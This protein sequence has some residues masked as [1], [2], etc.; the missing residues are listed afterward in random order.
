MSGRS[1]RA[2]EEG[3]GAELKDMRDTT[4]QIE[5]LRHLARRLARSGDLEG[6]AARF[7]EAERIAEEA[8]ETVQARLLQAERELLGGRLQEALG[9]AELA[10]EVD[11]ECERAQDL[12]AE[13]LRRIRDEAP[14]Q[15]GLELHLC[16]RVGTYR[17]YARKLARSTDTVIELG[18]AEGHTTVHL[19]RRVARVIAV[20]KTTQSLERGR[21][22]CADFDNI[23]WLQCDAFETGEVAQVAPQADLVFIDVGGSTWPSIALRLAAIYRHMFRPRAIVIRNVELNDFVLAARD[24]EQDAEAGP[25]RNPY[26]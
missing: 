18:A 17:D 9:A 2:T 23:L 11:A 1:A 3:C 4:S 7:A 12:R 10:L 19:A 21:E 16:A 5:A 15:T 24:C 26:R 14:P 25:W 22:R 20:E 8:Q 6:A 13:A